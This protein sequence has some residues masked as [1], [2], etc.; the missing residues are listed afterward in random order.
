MVE[1]ASDLAPPTKQQVP[2]VQLVVHHPSITSTLSSEVITPDDVRPLYSS[3]PC[4]T[5]CKPHFHSEREKIDDT[6]HIEIENIE[7]EHKNN[8]IKKK[9]TTK[10][11]Q[12]EKETE[13]MR[14]SA[15]SDE[16]QAET[17]THDTFCSASIKEHTPQQVRIS[18]LGPTTDDNIANDHSR[19]IAI[20]FPGAPAARW[21]V[22]LPDSG[23][24][25]IKATTTLAEFE[26]NGGKPNEL[27]PYQ[28][29][30]LVPKGVGKDGSFKHCGIWLTTFMV[31]GL[32]R[33]DRV[34]TWQSPPIRVAVVDCAF[35]FFSVLLGQGFLSGRADLINTGPEPHLRLDT[36]DGNSLRVPY[37]PVA[38]TLSSDRPLI[39]QLGP[40]VDI[41]AL[42]E[43][44]SVMALH[45]DAPALPA[46]WHTAPPVS[47]ADAATVLATAVNPYDSDIMLRMRRL[48]AV[49]MDPST[50]QR[51]TLVMRRELASDTARLAAKLGVCKL[52][53]TNVATTMAEPP[54]SLSN[55]PD[56]SLP[57]T[58]QQRIDDIEHAQQLHKQQLERDIKQ[59][60]QEEIKRAH[61]IMF[62]F[63][64]RLRGLT[65]A[66]DVSWTDGSLLGASVALLKDKQRK[67]LADLLVDAA[68]Q[69]WS[70]RY[71]PRRDG[72]CS[73]PVKLVLEL[74]PGASAPRDRSG[75]HRRF[76]PPAQD[77]LVQQM[78]LMLHAGI[79][80]P[81]LQQ[82][83]A[84]GVVMAKKKDGRYRFT[85]DYRP[86]NAVLADDNYPLPDIEE[87][88]RELAA[89]GGVFSTLDLSD[90]FWQLEL[91]ESQR[92]WTAF[93]VPGHG[94]FQFRVMPQGVKTATA[95]FQRNVE[96]IFG[97][98][99]GT[100]VLVY[101]DDLVVYSRTAKEHLQLLDQVFALIAKYDLR[102]SIDKAK[103]MQSSIKILGRVVSCHQV[104]VDDSSIKALR[105]FPLPDD[106]SALRRFLGLAGYVSNYIPMSAAALAP[107]FD[108]L[109]TS[110]QSPDKDVPNERRPLLWTDESKR[111]FVET[112]SILSSPSTLTV[113]P[114]NK[115]AGRIRI[116]S[117]ARTSGGGFRGAIGG[118]V[119]WKDDNGIWRLVSS[120]SRVMT[121]AESKYAPT[122]A[123]MLGAVKTVD[124]ATWL[125]RKVPTIDL[126]VDHQALIFLSRLGSLEHGRLARWA[127]KL[128]AAG[129][130]VVY[131]RGADNVVADAISRIVPDGS[132]LADV[133][134][135]DTLAALEHAAA[136]L[137]ESDQIE[138]SLFEH[139]QLLAMTTISWLCSSLDC[140]A[141]QA[142]VDTCSIP[143]VSLASSDSL[144]TPSYTSSPVLTITSHNNDIMTS[145]PT[146]LELG[147]TSHA[148]P[149]DIR[150]QLS[151]VPD[152][153]FDVIF[154][155]FPAPHFGRSS[156]SLQTPVCRR[157]PWS[158]WDQLQLER[159]AAPNA[160]LI[161]WT[162]SCKDAETQAAVARSGFQHRSTI[163]W[164]KGVATHSHLWPKQQIEMFHLSVRGDANKLLK[165]NVQPP[166][167]VCSPPTAPV[168]RKPEQVFEI[169]ESL[170][171]PGLR[172][173]ELFA[174]RY[175]QGWIPFGDQTNLLPQV[176]TESCDTNCMALD[177]EGPPS[178]PALDFF[179]KN[180]DAVAISQ[181]LDTTSATLLA[182]L[183]RDRHQMNLPP[184]LVIPQLT[185]AQ[186]AETRRLKS[187]D[188]LVMFFPTTIGTL[189]QL[190][191][192]GPLPLSCW[193]VREPG[194]NDLILDGLDYTNPNH[195]LEIALLLYGSDTTPLPFL[196]EE[197]NLPVDRIRNREAALLHL[198]SSLQLIRSFQE[199]LIMRT[200][201][202]NAHAK[203]PR[204][205]NLLRMSGYGWLNMDSMTEDIL[206]RKCSDCLRAIA[207]PFSWSRRSSPHR[208]SSPTR[209]GVFNALV[210][211]DLVPLSG[212][213]ENSAIL[214]I[215]CNFTGLCRLVAVAGEA[216]AENVAQLYFEHW[217]RPYGHAGAMLTDRGGQFTDKVILAVQRL[218]GTQQLFTTAY[219][220]E[221]NSVEER[222]HGTMKSWLRPTMITAQ[223]AD[224]E[225]FKALPTVERA[226]NYTVHSR[227]GCSPYELV[228]G[229]PPLLPATWQSS[230][231][232]IQA[233]RDGWLSGVWLQSR[234]CSDSDS[235]NLTKTH[236]D[237]AQKYMD[238]INEHRT[239]LIDAVLQTAAKQDYIARSEF[240]RAQHPPQMDLIRPGCYI[241]IYEEESLIRRAPEDLASRGL[242]SY[243]W[244]EFWRVLQLIR[245]GV[246]LLV[247]RADDPLVTRTVTIA[248]A[249]LASDLSD[250]QLREFDTIYQQTEMTRRKLAEERSRAFRQPDE[251]WQNLDEGSI[252][253]LDNRKW[254][255]DRILRHQ[256]RGDLTFLQ[257]RYKDT[258]HDDHARAAVSWQ[259]L[260]LIRYD[261][262][263]I[264][265]AYIGRFKRCPRE[266]KSTGR[267]VPGSP[268][269][270]SPLSSAATPMLSSS[271]S[272]S[273]SSSSSSSTLRS[274]ATT[275]TKTS[276]GRASRLPVR[277]QE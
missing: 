277:F 73:L 122:E 224:D 9:E 25:R 15:D 158:A 140:N 204:L 94:V 82:A 105:D 236:Y 152:G 138:D 154:V 260:E 63:I 84:A 127:A 190:K 209:S 74:K 131:R 146:N 276:S 201:V 11:K 54:T 49:K 100:G 189:Y 165:G 17:A 32:D 164:D 42:V 259:P 185:K 242:L 28:K 219:H 132:P 263:E 163:F 264:L 3:T 129:I 206:A 197:E 149:L 220:P 148:N 115:L 53:E 248:R 72:A 68:K 71:V 14:T 180:V 258:E 169:I 254:A 212:D 88:C 266:L 130:N 128:L 245:G 153:S 247:C 179:S 37:L 83:S 108:L 64:E 211:L 238:N 226:L 200:H 237:R 121:P 118:V 50:L 270:P 20:R 113:P 255:I 124:S 96:A 234:A 48:R 176:Q 61:D 59:L 18:A 271:S 93:F 151:E 217:A 101:V 30:D 250:H 267:P 87:V 275:M 80:E 109:K 78:R 89:D 79:L 91:L 246:A 119:E 230:P 178:D 172:K 99:I 147:P 192:M 168:G 36:A 188:V 253:L 222:L 97:P 136:R 22:A 85:V 8:N 104:C 142:P 228:F 24:N 35:P 160:L 114:G 39:R 70:P 6:P 86:L 1:G 107:M 47:P 123:E 117:D 268:E 67:E 191:M 269:V 215:S 183:L 58:L 46:D 244:S 27:L 90:A 29:G 65:D 214:S 55:E 112:R 262:P 173:A 33:H 182:T 261:A 175:R 155:D 23:G 40:S 60:Q 221:G 139:T 205:R 202:D 229:L 125:L 159:V 218:N 102:A 249:R 31:I 19:C 193:L 98:L 2:R 170:L 273:P 57:A 233:H 225:W 216:T 62:P 141:A 156:S 77:A 161:S 203:M 256:V 43:E 69:F 252:D 177:D 51:Q 12:T 144:S 196:Y 198:P 184:A 194:D 241:R 5:D 38:R 13:E 274:S 257:I 210:Q 243:R 223:L 199:T 52:E 232:A 213:A 227:L 41:H 120:Y 4:C 92:A 239:L 181:Q 134:L 26:R 251:E 66:D 167:V 187:K 95:A 44:T 135:P 207:R 81:S 45:E 166:S 137:V 7:R 75:F 116:S 208:V 186:K 162:S 76:A 111:A 171:K 106:V 143:D 10:T 157:L 265:Q 195:D 231:T 133:L 235:H 150:T 16:K 103:I 272:S 145:N 56:L 126:L 174:R 21:S 240:A 110:T 34:S